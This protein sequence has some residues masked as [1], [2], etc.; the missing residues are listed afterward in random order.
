MKTAVLGAGYVGVATAVGVAE[1]GHAVILVEQDAGRL[2]ALLDGRVPFHE[3]GLPVAYAVQHAA[4]QIVPS[5][6][7]PGEGLDLIVICVGTPI[8]DTGTTDVSQVEA[9]LDQAAPAIAGGAACVIRST[10][11]VGTAVRL[12][13]RS[14]VAPERFFVAPEFLRREAH[15]MTS[16][17]PRGSSWGA[18]ASTQTP[19]RWRW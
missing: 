4:G 16:A 17:G 12:A 2:A 7:I 18:S 1:R 8:D 5:A 14:G 13:N 3:P 19:T 9:A 6:E 10:L 15:S 11:P